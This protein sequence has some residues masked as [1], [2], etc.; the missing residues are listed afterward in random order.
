MATPLPPNEARFS[1]AQLVS[2]TKGR[3]LAGEPDAVVAGVESDSRAP[4]ADKVFVAL[5]GERFDGHDFVSTAAELGARAMIVSRDVSV[6]TG[7]A[8]VRVDS[9][10]DAL[11]ELGRAHRARH[12]ATVVAIAGSAGK[13]TTK[14][15]VAALLGALLPGQVLSAAGNLNNRIG[16][17]RVLLGLSPQHR[18]AVVELGTNATGEVASLA[19]I[20]RPDVAVLTLI[21]IEHSEGL[22]DLD[23]IEREE[24][25]LL[26]ALSADGVAIGNGD[27]ERVL[28]QLRRAPT[29]RQLAY[30]SGPE[31]DYRVV[32][33][34]ARGIDGAR[35][36]ISSP[37]GPALRF[38]VGLMGLPG[39]LAAAA[40]VAVAEQLVAEPLSAAALAHAFAG[41]VGEEG[42]LRP[43]ALADGSVVIDDTYNAN[44]ASVLA[45]VG[46]AAEL[47]RARGAGLVLVLGEMRE[48]GAASVAEHER[49][50]RE[51]SGSGARRLIAVAGDAERMVAP[52]RQAGL[53]ADF[54]ADAEAALPTVRAALEPGDV[55][56][57][58]ASRG[59]RAERIVRGLL[60]AIGRAG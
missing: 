23:A 43:I 13:T 3:L 21:D 41:A 47:A 58:K 51:L 48:L 8:V 37:R 60:S 34:E 11:G 42:R 31:A 2:E 36:T 26:Q 19:R 15:C 25:A 18:V 29:R 33:R 28:R 30:G 27:D 49:V 7:I 39:A 17:P 55:V 56:L 50:G 53:A 22:G 4:L 52:A 54:V 24:G 45:A 44:P 40:A 59:V 16:L 32:E 6:P 46:T 38:E 5:E 14:S 57:V 9:T 1:V 10:L 35:L 20:A 12:P